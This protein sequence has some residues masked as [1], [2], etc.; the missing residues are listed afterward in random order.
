MKCVDSSTAVRRNRESWPSNSKLYRYVARRGMAGVLKDC[1]RLHAAYSGCA[2]QG[3]GGFI[4]NIPH[5]V[6]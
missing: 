6:D 1:P 4:R 2:V 3:L 5:A